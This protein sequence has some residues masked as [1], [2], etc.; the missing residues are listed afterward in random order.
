[1]EITVKDTEGQRKELSINVPWESVAEDYSD[2]LK[3][4]SRL[5]VKGFRPGKMSPAALEGMF[6]RQIN[7]DLLSAV[8]RRLCRAALSEA[9]LEAGSPL[10]ISESELKKGEY[11]KLTASFIEMPR[12]ELPDYKNLDLKSKDKESQLDEISASLLESI[13]TT[14]HPSFVEDELRYSEGDPSSERER[15]AAAERVKLMLILKKIAAQDG[16]ETDEKDV[17]ERIDRIAADN[18]VTPAQLREYL[19]EGGGLSRLADSLLAEAV[20]AYIIE[21]NTRSTT[22]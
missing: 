16:I 14:L 6:R 11:L 13:N 7:S 22:T 4:Y 17:E 8:S 19:M 21:L 9:G 2:L 1:M 15:A 20:L 5:T 12:F 10:E 3:K 18:G